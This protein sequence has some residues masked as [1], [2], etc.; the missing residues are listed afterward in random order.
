MFSW[1]DTA[2][3]QSAAEQ[4]LSPGY[5]VAGPAINLALSGGNPVSVAAVDFDGDGN[6]DYVI[7]DYA[8]NIYT[9]LGLGNGSFGTVNTNSAGVAHIYSLA[10]GDLNQDTIPDVVL[11]T[12]ASNILVLQG[13]STGVLGSP[14]SVP[15]APQ[16]P[17]LWPSPISTATTFWISRSEI[18][19]PATP[20]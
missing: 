16:A 10:T 8:G 20:M 12:G 6:A 2:A 15:S 19:P 1:V 13:N 4:S 18:R 14:N 5:F 9:A 7:V 11:S 17:V 3:R